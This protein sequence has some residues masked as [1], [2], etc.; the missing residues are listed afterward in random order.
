MEG[1]KERRGGRRM[2]MVTVSG[3]V[4]CIRRRRSKLGWVSLQELPFNVLELGSWYS[5]QRSEDLYISHTQ[6]GL[7]IT[8]HKHK[9]NPQLWTTRFP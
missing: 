4:E 8:T 1:I 2:V 3:T 9:H 7:R 6:T 5:W